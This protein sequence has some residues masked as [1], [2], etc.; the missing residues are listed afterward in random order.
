MKCG[1][2]FLLVTYFSVFKLWFTLRAPASA[3]APESPITFPPRLWKGYPRISTNS[4]CYNR[5]LCRSGFLLIAHLIVII[6]NSLKITVVFSLQL[7][8]NM[9]SNSVCSECYCCQTFTQQE[10]NMITIRPYSC[11]P[12]NRQYCK[13]PTSTSFTVN[14]TRV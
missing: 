6:P 2:S 9:L 7:L 13:V 14:S 4:A 8:R 3:D 12:R 1:T 5:A 10:Q 11:S